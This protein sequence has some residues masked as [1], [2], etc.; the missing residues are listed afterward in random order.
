M[1]II[2]DYVLATGDKHFFER[3]YEDVTILT[4]AEFLI[5]L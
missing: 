1:R 5:G 3:K 4:P 2:F